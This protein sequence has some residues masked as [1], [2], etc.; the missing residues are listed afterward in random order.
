MPTTRLRP[1]A[2]A[3]CLLALSQVL[4]AQ[5][6]NTGGAGDETGRSRFWEL[7][8]PEGDHYMVALN[9]IVSIS[10]S[11]YLLDGG[12]I[13]TEINIDT[14]GSAL[15]RIYQI[16]PAAESAVLDGAKI[17]TDRARQGLNRASEVTG[18]NIADMVQKNYPTT[19]HAKT[20]EYRIQERE[21]LDRLYQS[22]TS[23]WTAN[24]GR[25]FTVEN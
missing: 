15:C 22:L 24:R 11:S 1:F 5:Q 14:N 17:L 6:N 3:L 8:L 10:R 9:R 23:A 7:S 13:V 4:P 25:R 2:A 21:T 18:S 20:I 12:L 16:T 19:T